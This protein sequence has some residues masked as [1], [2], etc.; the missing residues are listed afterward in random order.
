[1]CDTKYQ[2]V[3][4]HPRGGTNEQ[5]ASFEPAH[6]RHYGR[7]IGGAYV[8]LWACCIELAVLKDYGWVLDW[9]ERKPD[10]LVSDSVGTR[11]ETRRKVS[12]SG[13]E[14]ASL[15]IGY[16]DYARAERLA[17]SVTRASNALLVRRTHPE[18][19]GA[20][21]RAQSRSA[22]C[23]EQRQTHDRDCQ[24]RGVV[25]LLRLLHFH[26]PHRIKGAT[27]RLS[28]RT[29]TCRCEARSE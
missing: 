6:N 10:L 25:H 20:C 3:R 29:I 16:V 7:S 18:G 14:V 21:A 9:M 8:P 12:D 1:L 17:T 23:S 27:V 13:V 19:F 5:P 26:G 4:R 15:R 2:R 24:L 11:V 22:G 28:G